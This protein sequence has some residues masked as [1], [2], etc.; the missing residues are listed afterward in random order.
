MILH[1]NYCKT[2]ISFRQIYSNPK[3]LRGGFHGARVLPLSISYLRRDEED[4]STL[5]L[6]Q[7]GNHQTLLRISF[8]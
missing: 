2:Q 6:G 1:Q 4:T 3:K 8:H 7:T 5:N